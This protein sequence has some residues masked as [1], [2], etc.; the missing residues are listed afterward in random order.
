MVKKKGGFTILELI[1]VLALMSIIITIT[2]AIY[3]QNNRIHSEVNIKSNL[4]TEAQNISKEITDCGM[5]SSGITEL[6]LL[7]GTKINLDEID[8]QNYNSLT[9]VNSQGKVDIKNP[10]TNQWLSVKEI[11]INDKYET[12]IKTTDDDGNEKQ[13]IE[14]ENTP[15][16]INYDKNLESAE[17]N[18]KLKGELKITKEKFTEDKSDNTKTRIPNETDTSTLSENVDSIL[19]KPSNLV[20]SDN[21]I[22]IN[23]KISDAASIE[24]YIN[25]SKKKGVNNINYSIP[26]QITFRNK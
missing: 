2:F 15:F 26:I 19:I 4:Q 17:D 1:L 11:I 16:V 6:T 13:T 9:L 22:N 23:N 8:E 21:S 10:E 20:A 3:S 14:I 5:E 24:I 25:L 18:D 7:D 12:K